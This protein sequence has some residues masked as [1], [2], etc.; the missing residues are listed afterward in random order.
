MSIPVI[1]FNKFFAK[2]TAPEDY[3][4]ECA[5][6]AAAF[7]EIGIVIC[8]DPRVHNENNDLFL[9]TMEKY[10]GLSDGKRDARPET[11]YQVG[12][13]P[14]LVERARN[15]CDIMGAYK[16]ED[17]P[18]SPCP[19]ELDAK[20]RFFWRIGDKPAT[21]KYP[22]LNS[23]PVIPPE[24]PE[25]SEVM[26]MWGTKMLSAVEILAEMAAV[27][28]GLPEAAFNNKMK[29]GPHLLAPTGKWYFV[30]L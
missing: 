4:A 3:K 19:P 27:G 15:H 16:D 21:T 28:F 17:K 22:T 30:C 2:E 29:F 11:G 26:N 23:D 9:D 18:L 12:V 25:W 6:V 24:I 8:K 20:W 14:E 5:K 7:H 13:T 1:D 10:F